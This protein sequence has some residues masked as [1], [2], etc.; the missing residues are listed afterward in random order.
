[1]TIPPL[2]QAVSTTK[3]VSL[4]PHEN[5]V[6]RCKKAAE[7]LFTA[8]FIVAFGISQSAVKADCAAELFIDKCQRSRFDPRF[9]QGSRFDPRFEPAFSPD[10]IMGPI[11]KSTSAEGYP[12]KTREIH[13]L[14]S[15]DEKSGVGGSVFPSPHPLY[16]L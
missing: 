16:N 13:I 10:R 3:I 1:M 12:I 5:N 2:R 6:S 8:A 7:I 11:S 4:T 14:Q 15:Y 9:D